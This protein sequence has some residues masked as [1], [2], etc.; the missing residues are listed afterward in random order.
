MAEIE[1]QKIRINLKSFDHLLLDLSTQEIVEAAKKTQAQVIGPVPLPMRKERFT[2]LISSHV[3]KDAR[4]QYEIRTYKRFV[5]IIS[6]TEKTLEALKEIN[7]SSG[8][9]IK[10][11][12]PNPTKKQHTKKKRTKPESRAKA[13]STQKSPAKPADT[14]IANT[15]ET[16]APK[17]EASPAK[18]E[19]SPAKQE[20]APAKQEV[21]KASKDKPAAPVKAEKVAKESKD[22]PAAAKATAPAKEGKATAGKAAKNSPETKAKPA[23]KSSKNNPDSPESKD[24]PAA[25]K[26]DKN[27][28]E[29]K[30]AKPAKNTADTDEAKDKG[31]DK[32]KDKDK[33]SKDK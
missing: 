16:P 2:L 22:K 3:D 30:S 18:Q 32:G 10:I 20:T 31:E 11:S 29:T 9:E 25:D 7:L 24:K 4:D 14:N 1:S 8:V 17:Q 26:L 12:F 15:P 13:I 19:A 27:S 28:P 23:D 6:P 33:N 21:A 5:E